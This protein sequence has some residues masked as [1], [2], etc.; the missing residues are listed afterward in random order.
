MKSTWMN[1]DFVSSNKLNSD[2]VNSNKLNN[3]YVNIVWS[4]TPSKLSSVSLNARILLLCLG[5][6]GT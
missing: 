6:G 3:D 2:Y 1:I 5:G 4:M